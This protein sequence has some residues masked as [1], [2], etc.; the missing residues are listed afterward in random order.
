MYNIRGGNL[1]CELNT[2]WQ[3]VEWKEKKAE[4]ENILKKR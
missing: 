3:V 1:V 2:D 4:Q